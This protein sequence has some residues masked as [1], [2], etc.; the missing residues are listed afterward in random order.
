MKTFEFL[1]HTADIKFQAF[2]KSIEEAF[3]NSAPCK[4]LHLR[5]SNRANSVFADGH[6]EGIKGD[7]A[8]ELGY[9][10]YKTQKGCNEIGVY[11]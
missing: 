1:E 2:G 6:A 5:H 10:K 9:P 8:A 3:S 4:L 11:Y 7:R